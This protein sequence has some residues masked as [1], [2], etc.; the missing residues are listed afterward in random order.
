MSNQQGPTLALRL[1]KAPRSTANGHI[2]PLR[3]A[4]NPSQLLMRLSCMLK[5]RTTRLESSPPLGSGA[6]TN[7]SWHGLP[8]CAKAPERKLVTVKRCLFFFWRG[9]RGGLEAFQ[10]KFPASTPCGQKKTTEK[11]KGAAFARTW[12]VAHKHPSM[13]RWGACDI[14]KSY[15]LRKH[16]KE[17]RNWLEFL[18]LSGMAPG[19]YLL[20]RI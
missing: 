3:Q 15:Q 13:M 2:L 6:G 20:L 1:A 5:K 4:K 12:S 14:R 18:R 10:D 19:L 17:A 16:G 9:G 7:L 8:Q 11:K